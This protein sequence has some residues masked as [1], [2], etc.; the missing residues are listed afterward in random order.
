MK[1]EDNKILGVDFTDLKKKDNITYEEILF[2]DISEIVKY[3][4]RLVFKIEYKPKVMKIKE[5]ATA[6][7]LYDYDSDLNDRVRGEI[8]RLFLNEEDYRKEL[9]MISDYYKKRYG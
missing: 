2:K 6:I 1:E 5:N 3:E 7:V 9:K 8:Y 4:P